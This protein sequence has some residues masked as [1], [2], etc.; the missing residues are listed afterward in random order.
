MKIQDI[1][2][3]NFIIFIIWMSNNNLIYQEEQLFDNASTTIQLRTHTM[4]SNIYHKMDQLPITLILNIIQSLYHEYKQ[5]VF[6][7]EMINVKKLNKEIHKKI[8]QQFTRIASIQV[9][10]FICENL[11]VF[12]KNIYYSPYQHVAYPTND[13]INHMVI[14]IIY[15]KYMLHMYGIFYFTYCHRIKKLDV[16]DRYNFDIYLQ[17][18]HIFEYFQ[19]HEMNENSV[20]NGMMIRNDNDLIYEEKNSTQVILLTKQPKRMKM[21]IHD[22][23]QELD[24]SIIQIISNQDLP[25]DILSQMSNLLIYIRKN[26]TL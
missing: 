23:L 14:Y 22:L 3:I 24:H 13:S 4:I 17:I 26:N 2:F 5:I 8:I 7:Q 6:T 1:I 21:N 10:R 18:N 9:I 16:I 11:F 19:S 25:V 20:D 15:K 12:S